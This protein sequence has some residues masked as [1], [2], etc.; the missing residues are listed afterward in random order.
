VVRAFAA[1]TLRGERPF[2]VPTGGSSGLAD[3]GFVS[4]AF[5][6]AEQVEVGALPEP[7]EIYVPIGSGGTL[8]GLVLGAKL[9]R[10]RA[11]VVGVLVTDI[12][13]PGPARLAR[14]ARASLAVLRRTDASVPDVAIDA[15][16]FEI[17]R[18]QLGPG[19]GAATPAAEA[20]TEAA[21]RA[22]LALETTYTAKCLAEVLARLA[23]GRARPPVLFWNTYNGADF[24]KA[25]PGGAAA[26]RMPAQIERWLAEAS[27]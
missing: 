2:W 7:N 20:A 21:R 27:P 17:A 4:A 14:L 3:L 23:D 15:S 13:P 19:Y 24:W 9:A 8:A 18:A 22:G 16:D 11:R 6:V 12:L 26:A 25:A 5:E 10:L 1:A